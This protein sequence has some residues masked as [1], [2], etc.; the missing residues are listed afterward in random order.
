[1]AIPI[2]LQVFE[3]PLDLLLHLIDKNKVDIY[4]IPIVLITEQYLAY[5]KQMASD[6]MDVVSE[7]LVMA[8]TLLQIKS[9]MLLP[10]ETE[11]EGETEDPREELMN[12]L[13]EYKKYKQM[14]YE[15]REQQLEGNRILYK[16]KSIPEEVQGYVLP[17]DYQE[18]VGDLSLKR[19]NEIFCEMIKRQE[20]KIDPI[21]SKYGKIEKDEVNLEEK[22][23]YVRDYI[24]N[25]EKVSFRSLL[26][27]QPSKM[28]VVVTFLV[29]LELMKV[30][31]ITIVQEQL[32]DDITIMRQGGIG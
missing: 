19:L 15:L 3:G 12:Q 30:G 1:M 5:I 4:D 16:T 11:E 32:F 8:A 28:S 22:M 13:L 27:K 2:K 23:S 6:D 21:R 14:S 29:I 18:L 7:F 10:V 26:E 17:I 24:R 25:H 31:T 20:D 9:K